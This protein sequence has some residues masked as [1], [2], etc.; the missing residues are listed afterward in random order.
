M[1]LMFLLLSQHDTHD[2]MLNACRFPYAGC[3][4]DTAFW[5]RQQSRQTTIWVSFNLRPRHKC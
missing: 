3:S 4:S 1:H 2:D 5:W